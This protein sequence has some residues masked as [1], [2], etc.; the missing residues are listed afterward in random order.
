MRQ[1]TE[2]ACSDPDF[3]AK[4]LGPDNNDDRK[5]LYEDPDLRFCILAHV[6]KGQ[7]NSNPHDHGPSWAVYGQVAGVTEMTDWRLLAKPAERR[8]RQGRKDAELRA[9]ARHRARLQRRRA[10]FAGARGRHKADPHRGPGPHQGEARQVRGRGLTLQRQVAAH[11]FGGRTA[12][13][14][15]SSR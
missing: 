5:I 4:H 13:A 14:S 12:I 11:P 7:K 8:A 6:Y 10:A 2:T 3:V 1:Y 15:T 9:H